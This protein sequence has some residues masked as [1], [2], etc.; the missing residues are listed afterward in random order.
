MI[1]ATLLAGLGTGAVAALPRTSRTKTTRPVVKAGARAVTEAAPGYELVPADADGFFCD[2]ARVDIFGYD[3][4]REATRESVFVRNGL[5]DTIGAVWLELEYYGM[6]S[7]PLHSRTVRLPLMLAPGKTGR[8]DFKSWDSQLVF[9]YHLS[10]APRR[11]AT[12]YKLAAK[13]RGAEIRRK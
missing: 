4:V 1:A 5:N 10:P 12:P 13:V 9:Y 6:D 11:Q 7:L 8:A 2:S 3:K